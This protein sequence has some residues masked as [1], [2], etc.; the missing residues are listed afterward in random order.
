MALSPTKD[1][2]PFLVP[3]EPAKAHPA[4]A[5]PPAAGVAP[6]VSIGQITPVMQ[7][8]PTV[9]RAPQP[10]VVSVM[11]SLF[12]KSGARRKRGL[13]VMTSVILL[14]VVGIVA[15]MAFSRMH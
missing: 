15:V 10:G 11:P 9:D 5:P 8:S 1:A 7:S 12:V 4:V 6:L 3:N 13:V 2:N 14:F